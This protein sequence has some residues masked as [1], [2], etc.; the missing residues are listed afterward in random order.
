MEA[1]AAVHRAAALHEAAAHGRR[2]RRAARVSVGGEVLQIGVAKAATW[3]PL[4][5]P[6]AAFL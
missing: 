1:T 6:L 4:G 5:A 2:W 3:T